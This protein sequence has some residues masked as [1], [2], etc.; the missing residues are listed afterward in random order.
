MDANGWMRAF[1]A[2]PDA[3]AWDDSGALA[4]AVQAIAATPITAAEGEGHYYHGPRG[5]RRLLGPGR[6]HLHPYRRRA[7]ARSKRFASR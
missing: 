1:K 5:A 7:L 6:E 2:G 3:V 4:A